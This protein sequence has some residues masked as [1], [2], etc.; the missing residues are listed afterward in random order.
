[1]FKS[2]NYDKYIWQKYCFKFKI[3]EIRI[4]L[5]NNYTYNLDKTIKTESQNKIQKQF[6]RI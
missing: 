3:V 4:N 5:V 6:N 2:L 1:M